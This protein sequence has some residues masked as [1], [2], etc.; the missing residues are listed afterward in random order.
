M[1]PLVKIN[2]L[3]VL[4]FSLQF[5]KPYYLIILSVLL[6]VLVW[7][8]CFTQ[9]MRMFKRMRWL[10]LFMLVIYAFNTP[11]QFV[12]HWPLSISPTYEG[13]WHGLN[14]ALKVI[15]MLLGITLLLFSVTREAFIGAIYQ[16]LKPLVFI[17][18]DCSRFAVRLWLTLTYA[19]SQPKIQNLT[20]LKDLTKQLQQTFQA[21]L[22]ENIDD[23]TIKLEKMCVADYVVLTISIIIVI[24]LVRVV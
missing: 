17:G 11:G 19:E 18:V 3:V 2:S 14:Q 8:Y 22:S 7:C 24:A 1:H 23:I 13:V 10:L 15:I 20:L 4:A 6:L 5:L 16:L 21:D 9:F 12:N